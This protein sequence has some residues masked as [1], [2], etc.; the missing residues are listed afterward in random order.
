[1]L[2]SGAASRRRGT[3]FARRTRAGRGVGPAGTGVATG[4]PLEP[5]ESRVLMSA[6]PTNQ[7]LTPAAATDAANVYRTF[8]AT[9]RDADGAADLS[10]AFLRVNDFVPNMLDCVY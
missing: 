9:Y 4:S 1:M 7:A 10:Q 2:M 3:F 6:A 8:T 5:L